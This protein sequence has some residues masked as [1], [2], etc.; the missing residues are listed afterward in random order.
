M[1]LFWRIDYLDSSDKQFK[2]RDLWLD[3]NAL[4][5]FDKAAVEAIYDL[6]DTG[7]SR[8]MLR[9]KHLFQKENP[10]EELSDQD[11]PFCGSLGTVSIH[12]YFEDESGNE[13]SRK[14]M[15]EV[16]TGNPN[17]VMLPSGAK[18]YQIDFALADRRPIPI[19]QLT[20]SPEAL[21]VLGYFTRDLRE[22]L[23]SALLR[24]G[25]GT[26]TGG[27]GCDWKLQTAATDEEIQSAVTIFRRLYM[28]N[29]RA[30]F[31]KAVAVFVDAVKDNPLAG[32]VEGIASEYEDELTKPPNVMPLLGC[33]NLHFLRKRLIDV[34]L[35]TLYAHQP[36]AKR[37]GQF[38][39][40][41][42]AVGNNRDMLTWLF[43]TELWAC[44]LH[45]SN[46]GRIIAEFYEQYCHY[47]GTSGNVIASVS[48]ESPGIGTLETKEARCER[49]LGEKA[50]ELAKAMWEKEGRPEGG[51]AR[52]VGAARAHLNAAIGAIGVRR[53]MRT[54]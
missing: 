13:L 53:E 29:E 14:R 8:D 46:A 16:L 44:S 38:E 6:Q 34:F 17:A 45:M 3:T 52:Y 1:L 28:R 2:D 4:E 27:E 30:S 20:L 21:N 51:H 25:P 10:F 37:S 32:R 36:D 9:Y 50:E 22:L 19:D 41:L 7:C 5:P 23:A 48:R 40:C 33:T 42:Q 15:A 18:Q 12:D 47:H 43:L 49:V 24:D 54:R 35:Y 26:L 31:V 11:R 39:E